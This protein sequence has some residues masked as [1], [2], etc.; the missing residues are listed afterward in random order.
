MQVFYIVAVVAVFVL[1]VALLSTARRILRSSPLAGGELGLG[2]IYD[3]E[4]EAGHADEDTVEN[5]HSDQSPSVEA[6]RREFGDRD[7]EVAEREPEPVRAYGLH[8]EIHAEV[9]VPLPI[10]P[11]PITNFAEVAPVAMDFD[12][13]EAAYM[14]ASEYQADERQISTGSE[15]SGRFHLPRPSR[16]T[17]QYALEC[18]LLGVSAY[19]LV[20]T[21]QSNIKLRSQQA[22]PRST[23]KGRVA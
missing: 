4:P 21:Q 23:S 1:C 14:H 13:F 16:Q 22:L 7:F 19:V 6:D 17:Y 9:A 20:R 15:K 11:P 18:L 10:A 8:R 12:S 3:A 5:I 2:R